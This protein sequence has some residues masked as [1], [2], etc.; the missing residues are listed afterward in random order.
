MGAEPV[1]AFVTLYLGLVLGVVDV[2]LTAS[3]DVARVELVLDGREAAVLAPPFRGR[4]DLGT[5]APHE[6]VAVARAADGSELARARQWINRPRALAE[7]DFVLEPGSGREGRVARLTWRCVTRENPRT[8]T[9]SFDGKPLA[10]A[11]PAR[12]VLP[13]HDPERLHFLRAELDFG[14]GVTTVADA[15][16]GG[17]RKAETLTSLTAVPIAHARRR[18][19]KLEDL[20]ASFTARGAPAL[21]VA[22]EEGPAEVVF[23]VAGYVPGELVRIRGGRPAYDAFPLGSG[24]D[25]RLVWC[26]PT[27][28][29]QS[30][31]EVAVFPMT[32]DI[33]PGG[34]SVLFHAAGLAP[35]HTRSE[36][37][38]AKAV[39]TAGLSAAARDRRRAVVL[40]VGPL[41]EDEGDLG[42][43]E[44]RDFLARLRVPLFVWSVAK[45]TPGLARRFGSVVD[46]STWE[47]FGEAVADLSELLA[48]QRIVWLEGS[49]L[50]QDVSLRAPPRGVTL[51]GASA[52]R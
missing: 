7:A 51:A 11:D 16:F 22:I 38:V 4:L 48:R 17:L 10:A 39:A 13:P 28:T 26:R 19:P 50:P 21:P 31:Q 45:E 46:A 52:E 24:Q 8:A 3:R 44:A 2:E 30:R 23:V 34:G 1:V 27:M 5:L 32:P 49:W 40:V 29:T 47:R 37:Q 6:L 12:I 18:A 14:D 15:T 9:I 20:R 41:A 33:P 25:Y 43:A 42:P 35:P 36:P